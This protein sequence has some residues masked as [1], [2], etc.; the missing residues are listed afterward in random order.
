MLCSGVS[1]ER[2]ALVGV[3]LSSLAEKLAACRCEFVEFVELAKFV[4][5]FP[6]LMMIT[7]AA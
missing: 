3:L 2:L 1:D 4:L 7:R 5:S 6:R